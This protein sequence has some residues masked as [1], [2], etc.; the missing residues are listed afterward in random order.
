VSHKYLILIINSGLQTP[1]DRSR[2]LLRE[3]GDMAGGCIL[4]QAMDDNVGTF[5]C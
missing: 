1:A 2:A 5:T 4:Q 3:T